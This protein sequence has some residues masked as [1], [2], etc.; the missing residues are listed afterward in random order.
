MI[1]NPQRGASVH[2][3]GAGPGGGAEDHQEAGGAAHWHGLSVRTHAALVILTRQEVE[4]SLILSM[5]NVTTCRL[6]VPGDHL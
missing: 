6:A 3:A 1:C 5:T 2:G 4:T